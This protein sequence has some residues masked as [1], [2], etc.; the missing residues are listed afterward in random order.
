MREYFECEVKVHN[1]QTTVIYGM[2]PCVT[3][4]FSSVKAFANHALKKHNRFY[5]IS[6]KR[7][8]ITLDNDIEDLHE[9]RNKKWQK[10]LGKMHCR[11]Y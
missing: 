9:T 11:D 3:G 8:A 7:R 2:H 1:G 4:V 10:Q 6:S 5:K